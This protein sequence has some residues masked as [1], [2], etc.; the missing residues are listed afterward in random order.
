MD[1]LTMD[2]TGKTG[3]GL[4]FDLD[5]SCANMDTAE[6]LQDLIIR[7]GQL[8]K[9]VSDA[10]GKYDLDRLRALAEADKDGRCVIMPCKV[11][12]ICYEVDPGHPGAIK[13][14]VTGTTIYNRQAD[15]NRYMADFVNITV[16]D[17]WAVAEDGCEWADQYTVAEWADAP[18]TRPEAEAA[19][20]GGVD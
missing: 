14:T 7:L 20:K 10:D 17:T 18:K 12:D 9:A 6:R 4:T 11:G 3:I 15:G 5:V 19:M 1:R 2:T 8:E 16:I 13:H